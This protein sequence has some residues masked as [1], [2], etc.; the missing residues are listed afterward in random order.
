VRCKIRTY[1]PTT[2]PTVLYGMYWHD[3]IR[4]VGICF[5]KF[6]CII[7]FNFFVFTT[8][9]FTNCDN[10]CCKPLIFLS[11]ASFLST[12]SFSPFK[13]NAL[14]FVP[15]RL[16]RKFSSSSSYLGLLQV[17]H[18]DA[19]YQLFGKAPTLTNNNIVF[20]VRGG[21]KGKNSTSN[22]SVQSTE[23]TTS[24]SA[25]VGANESDDSFESDNSSDLLYDDSDGDD[26]LVGA[27]DVAESKKDTNE[28]VR[29]HHAE[30]V[31]DD[32]PR[33]EDMWNPNSEEPSTVLAKAKAATSRE[34]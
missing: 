23:T 22:H 15:S 4:T 24:L 20:K 13:C 10:Y 32:I 19:T 29:I 25:A 16:S 8:M 9:K 33:S 12:L 26:M 31:F 11:V 1:V 3:L 2:V 21:G 34:V 17:V 7:D 27:N 5:A 28:D 30:V 18:D 14:S 6:S